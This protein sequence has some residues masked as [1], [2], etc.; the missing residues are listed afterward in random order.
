MSKCK[1]AGDPN[2]VNCR[3]CDGLYVLDLSNCSVPAEH[4]CA[5]FEADPIVQRKPEVEEVPVNTDEPKIINN[6]V[7]E[8]TNNQVISDISNS[9]DILGE[10]T[11]IS[12]KSGV[13]AEIKGR[14]YK[15]EFTEE[16]VLPKYCNLHEE[17]QSLWE[18][19]NAEVD[20]QLAEITELLK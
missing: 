11:K 18:S 19:V 7:N 15:F 2:D 14:W 20:N 10:T 17:K 1:Y 12:A 5:G 16:R 13:S 3:T 9:F 6:V 4:H 8:V